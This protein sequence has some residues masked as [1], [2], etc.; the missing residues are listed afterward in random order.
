MPASSSMKITA[1]GAARLRAELQE[2]LDDRLPEL[3]Q[4]VQTSAEDGD[5]T[6]NSEWEESKDELARA[7]RRIDDIRAVLD[8]YTILDGAGG[9]SVELGSTITVR[10][11]DG[12]EIVWILVNPIEAFISED[13]ISVDS[14]VG[15]ALLGTRAGSTVAVATPGG[16]ASYTVLAVN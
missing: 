10:A 7:Q 14:P 11:D 6:D 8:T 15:R 12:E 5:L 13:R 16:E 9:E 4:I 1:E 3:Q 2:L